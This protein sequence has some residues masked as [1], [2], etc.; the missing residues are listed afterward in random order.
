MIRGYVEQPRPHPGRTHRRTCRSTTGA[1]PASICYVAVLAEG[2][3]SGYQADYC[4]DVDLDR[5]GAELLT[6]HQLLV[7]VGH[8]E[9]WSDA[10]R[11]AVDRF[12][13]A[14][15][16]AAFFGGNT[17]WWRVAFPDKVTFSRVGFWHEMGQPVE[18]PLHCRGLPVRAGYR[19]LVPLADQV[20]RHGQRV[21][22][23]LA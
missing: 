6:P 2:D 20:R 13:A 8:D 9:Y 19:R 15:G 17:C 18:R 3:P 22:V 14:G 11:A 12:V 23:R 10:M 1:S 21:H 16:N 7:S 5:D 4:T